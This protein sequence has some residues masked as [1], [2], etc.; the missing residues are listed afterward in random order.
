MKKYFGKQG[1]S[2]KTKSDK[3]THLPFCW[4]R[5]NP[6]FQKVDACDIRAPHKHITKE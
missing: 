3:T 6:I 4:N 2:D 5:W 1:G